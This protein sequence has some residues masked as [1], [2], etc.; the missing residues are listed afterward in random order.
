LLHRFDFVRKHKRLIEPAILHN[1]VTISA[2]GFQPTD[3]FIPL[4][5]WVCVNG[6]TALGLLKK[7]RVDEP[8]IQIA[9]YVAIYEAGPFN[10]K[11]VIETVRAFA[12]V[13]S[14]IVGVFDTP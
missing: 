5:D 14:R 3:V 10:R 11:G 8:K 4:A 12:N 2:W 1:L 6:E 13:A 9:P 7:N